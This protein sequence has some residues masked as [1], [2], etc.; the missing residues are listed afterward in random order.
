MLH[1]VQD[2]NPLSP[3]VNARDQPLLVSGDVEDCPSAHLIGAPEIGPPL[4]ESYPLRLP[5]RRDTF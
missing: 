2:E 4:G 3:I 5:G 1:D